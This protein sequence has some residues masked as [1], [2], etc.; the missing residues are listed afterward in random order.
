M[1][2]NLWRY[3]KIA[4][5]RD[6]P[7]FVGEFG[8]NARQGNFGEDRWLADMLKCFND[9]GFHWTYWTYKAIKNQVFPD[10]IYSYVNNPAWVHRVGP[11]TG[12]DTYKQHWSK[13]QKPMIKSWHTDQ[14][15]ANTE[16][17]K[18]LENAAR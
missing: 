7:I 17:L 4:Q 11:L 14:F 16:I 2:R 15:Q 10:G 12:W 6:V 18:V 5:K 13:Q 8:V 9:Y 1:R 3:K